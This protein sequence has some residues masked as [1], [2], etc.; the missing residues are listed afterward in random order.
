M[1]AV[2]QLNV[3][4]E[5]WKFIPGYENMYL[6][7]NLGN[8]KSLQKRTRSG[9]RV[10]KSTISNAGYMLIDLVKDSKVKKHSV[11]RLVAL[12]FIPNPENKSQVN[13]INGIKTDNRSENL[14]WNTRSE[15]Q[16]HSIEIGLRT[17][18]G[19]KNSQ[20]K[21][22]EDSVKLIFSD[23]RIYKEIAKDYNVSDVTICDIKKGRSWTHI[24]GLVNLKKKKK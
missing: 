3:I 10:L 12:S 11:H 13:H 16:L 8:V 15:N 19:V 7:S 17:T 5:E 23:R 1:F 20:V 4:M 9:T 21:L 14:E 2:E 24:T 22:T 18:V 6:A